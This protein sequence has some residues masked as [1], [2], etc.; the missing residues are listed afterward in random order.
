MRR[1]CQLDRPAVIAF[2]AGDARGALERLH[3]FGEVVVVLAVPL[4]FQLGIEG[5]VGRALG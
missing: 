5:L 1:L 2:L 3:P 4:P